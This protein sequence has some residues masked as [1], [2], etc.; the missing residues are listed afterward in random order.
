M[1]RA[2]CCHASNTKWSKNY[3]GKSV[4]SVSVFWGALGVDF[5]VFWGSLGVS[6]GSFGGRGRSRT[7]AFDFGSML[8]PK[9]PPKTTPRRPQNESKIKT[10]NASLFYRSWTLLG[11]VLR[12]S[13]AHLGVKKVALAFGFPMFREHRFF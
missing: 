11:P 5:E 12:P 2:L 3:L 10:K 8:D 9:T 13:W 6:W 1:V 7:F 4:D